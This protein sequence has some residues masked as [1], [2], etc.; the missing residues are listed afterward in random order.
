MK[1]LDYVEYSC[2]GG[3]AGVP[4]QFSCLMTAYLT[5]SGNPWGFTCL[6]R[7]SQSGGMER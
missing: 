4:S 3:C 7:L 6:K 2:K 1:N 5:L